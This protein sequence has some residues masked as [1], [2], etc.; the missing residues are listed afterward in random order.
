M[1][2]A[3][4]KKIHSPKVTFKEAD[5]KKPWT[6]AEGQADLITF[7]LVLEHIKDLKIV[8]AEAMKCLSPTG[9]IYICE[10]HPYKHLAG[11]QARFESEK[12][13]V[14]V[15]SYIHHISE[16]T[17]LAFENNLKISHLGEW[18]DDDDE[19]LPRLISFILEK[20]N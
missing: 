17:N 18:F 16:F 13:T 10:W 6:F 14:L 8:F 3:A 20:Q 12:G 19:Q 11:G 2:E 9:K 5:V 1:L 15:E 7:S 4:R